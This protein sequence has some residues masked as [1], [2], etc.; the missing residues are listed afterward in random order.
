M[1]IIGINS[2]RAAPL[3]AD[4]RKRRRLADGG[5]ALLQD[6][7]ISCAA[8]EERFTRVRYAAGFRNSTLACMRQ[9]GIDL[10]MLDAVGHSTCC[11]I[12]WSNHD[13]IIDDISETMEGIFPREQIET[14]KRKVFTVDHH[15]SHAAI[16]FAAS[17]FQKALVAVIDGMGNRKG[18]AEDFNV[19]DDWWRGAFQRHS[20]YICEW[21]DGRIRF[22][23]VH[24][25]AGGVD[26]IGVGEIYRSVTH[27]LGWPSYQHAGKTMALASFGRPEHLAVARFIEFVPPFSVRVPVPN[28]HCNP[29]AQ[30]DDA[31]RCVGYHLPGS[32]S[33]ENQFLCDVAACVQQQ[34]ESALVHAVSALADAYGME[35]VAF[36]G[37]VAM[38]CVA[39]GKL[40]SHRPDLHLYVPPAPGDTG[41]A[42]GNALWLAYA[43]HSPIAEP[44]PFV[45]IRTAAL[46]VEYLQSEIDW[47]VSVHLKNHPNVVARRFDDVESLAETVVG[48][49]SAG[50]V[51]GLRQGRSEY[52]PRALGQASI[53]ADPRMAKMHDIV[54]SFK[55]RE[56]FRPYAPSILSEYV[57]EYFEI[58]VPSPFMSFAGRIREEKRSLVPAA[59][60]VDG[61]ARYQSVGHDAGFYRLLL[62]SWHRHT[63]I[64]V[65]LNTS[66]NMN[67]EPIVETPQDALDCFERSGLPVLVLGNWH[68]ERMHTNN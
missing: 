41:L 40:A 44:A 19:S 60:H 5:A 33:P 62:E 34:L 54:N 63:G 6:G 17:G 68:L 50:K 55:Q 48:D 18:S 15:E 45:A 3:R 29:I 16:A 38:N 64:P 30:I 2:S 52:G 58:D 24:E 20:Y 36:G 61:S 26:E 23:K 28:L 49:L 65:L 35:N 43:E 7:K 66:L 27:F 21:R 46:G 10:G 4:P 13:D 56:P 37:G 12:A 42:L 57:R 67:G 14:L 22:E 25:D 59:V 1:N 11:D 53:V 39:L 9:G 31:I 32:A 47:A 8:I 51:V